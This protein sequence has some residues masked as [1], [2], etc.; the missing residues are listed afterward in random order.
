MHNLFANVRPV[1]FIVLI[2]FVMSTIFMSVVLMMQQTKAAGFAMQTGYYVGTGAAGKVVSGVGFQADLI[3]IKGRSGTNAATSET[4]FRS[5]GMAA[6]NAAYFGASA[7]TTVT[8]ITP[9]SDG[10]VLGLN[11]AVNAVNMVYAWTAFTGSDCTSTGNFCVGTYTGVGG[12]ARTITTG[13]QPSLVIVKRSNGIGGHFRTAS[14]PANQ[15][16]YFNTTANDTSGALISS[17]SSTGFSVGSTDN[18]NTGIYYYIAFKTTAGAFTEGTYTGNATDNRD[19]TG[20]GFTPNLVM[21][22][23]SSSAIAANRNSVMSSTEYG[24]DSSNFVGDVAA[25]FVDFPDYIQ[26][27]DTGSFQVGASPGVNETGATIYWFAFGGAP[28]L[29]GASGTYKMATGTYTGTGSALS[30]SSLPF[31][32]DLVMIKDSG[33]NYMVF[34]TSMM[35][36]NIS[37]YFANPLADFNNAITS[38]DA[39]GFSIGTSPVVNTSGR[40]LHWQAF[41]NA[42]RPDTKRGAADFSIGAYA[43]TGLAETS[44]IGAPYQMDF[45]GIKNSGAVG[46]A[47]HTSSQGND[48]TG[49]FTAASEVSGGVKTFN[50]TGFQVG[51]NAAVNANGGTY[52]WFGFKA[53]SNFAVG[54][55]TGTNIVDQAVTVGTGMQPDLMWIQQSTDASAPVSRPN[56]VTG[57][58]S[59]RFSASANTG[60]LIKSFT[61]TGATLGTSAPVNSD[62]GVYRYMAW[63]IPSGNLTGD[64][65][66]ATGAPVAS[67]HFTMN[68]SGYPYACDEIAGTLGISSQ[69]IRVSNMT[70]SSAWSMSIAAT[71]GASA[72]WRNAGNT[73][74]YDYN[75]PNG[76]PA[77]CS[78]GSDTDSV[79][80]KLRIEPSGA[81][82]TPQAGCSTTNIS[83][84]SNQ[85][86]NESTTSAITL[87]TASS[88]ANVGCYWDLTGVNLRQYIPA[89]QASDSYSLNL[90]ITTIAQ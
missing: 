9:N 14:M 8:A 90:T 3:I 56:T 75:E 51:T 17:L 11:N 82:I 23:N 54:N 43:S 71:E 22:K 2:L 78:D 57:D 62:G 67:P 20:L 47:F 58:I 80:G 29:S 35:A 38:I 70:S 10:F 32:P 55:Y 74:Q 15:S 88:S 69:K 5:T 83:R 18:T 89:G 27:L 72:L 50:S 39:N 42:Y 40:V 26:K 13:F 60:G 33:A 64:I 24:G 79:A 52:R 85:D 76:S 61:S 66:D 87:M 19:T 44:I 86:F 28:T 73:Q 1:R 37:S 84:G 25:T 48:V 34:R 46:A 31:S 59:Q 63:R 30:V 36:G 12:G 53:S 77:G 21:A 45:I 6:T 68:N 65:V 4:V 7:D 81:T 16:S 41:G 49:F